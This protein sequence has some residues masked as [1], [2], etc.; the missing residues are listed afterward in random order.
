MRFLYAVCL[1]LIALIDIQV[2]VTR[3]QEKDQ[4]FLLCGVWLAGS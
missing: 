2:A 3:Q 4:D 1:I